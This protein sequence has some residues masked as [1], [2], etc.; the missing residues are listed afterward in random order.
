M[1][2]STKLW[3][4]W[5]STCKF[6]NLWHPRNW[7]VFSYDKSTIESN[8]HPNSKQPNKFNST[9]LWNFLNSINKFPNLWHLHNQ[10]FL[11]WDKSI[12]E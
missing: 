4:F 11:I 8:K 12:I 1:S 5:N 9:K 3:S 6:S 7:N 2:T 10:N